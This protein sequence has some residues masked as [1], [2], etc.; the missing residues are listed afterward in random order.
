M[1]F[2]AEIDLVYRDFLNWIRVHAKTSKKKANGVIN[3]LVVLAFALVIA[4]CAIIVSADGFDGVTALLMAGAVICFSVVLFRNRINARASQKSFTKNLGTIHL[5][6]NDEAIF[7]KTL[8]ADEKY[9]YSGLTAFYSNG[10]TYYLLLDKNHALILPMRC[11]TEGDPESF[12]DFLSEKT[13]LNVE[14]V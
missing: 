5:A 7:A 14:T 4:G 13:G 3:I 8:K 10:D 11:F 12:A 2:K 9:Y 6:V 1:E